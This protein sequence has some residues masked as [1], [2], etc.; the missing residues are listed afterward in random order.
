MEPKNAK[1]KPSEY[2]LNI[3]YR[4][5]KCDLRTWLTLEEARSYKKI[6][7]SFC[8]KTYQIEIPKVVLKDEQKDILAGKIYSVPEDR[9]ETAGQSV[10]LDSTAARLNNTAAPN[11]SHY[12]SLLTNLGY[13]K[14]EA[15]AKIKSINMNGLSEEE[16]LQKI[17]S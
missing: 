13:K 12:I 7:C 17:L 8:G 1:L 5:R 14:G 2:Q 11:I 9:R 3:A 16:I 6:V 10:R 15:I 4:C